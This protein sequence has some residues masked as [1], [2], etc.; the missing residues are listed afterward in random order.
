MGNAERGMGNAE[1]GM[2]RDWALDAGAFEHL[3]AT[4]DGNRDRAAEKYERVRHK[5]V[6]FFRWRGCFDA[7]DHADRTIDRVARRLAEGAELR[8]ADPYLYF[9]GVALRVL[10]EVWRAP[11]TGVARTGELPAAVAIRANA[12]EEGGA[13]R[14][15]RL[16]CLDRCLESLDARQRHLLASYHAAGGGQ[17]AA[18]RAL[19]DELGIPLNALRIRTH[20]IRSALARCVGECIQTSTARK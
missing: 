4:L 18:R 20:R 11:E 17:I 14:E 6:S 13:E 15:R 5:L 3:L 9:H 2:R 12:G 16:S 7:E 8:V 19:A 1:R 10:Q